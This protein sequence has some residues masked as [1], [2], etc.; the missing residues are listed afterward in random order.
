[1]PGQ[2]VHP[3]TAATTGPLP[4]VCRRVPN[5]CSIGIPQNR[6]HHLSVARDMSADGRRQETGTVEEVFKGDGE[7]E[8][9][10]LE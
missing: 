9:D 3:T 8:G 10:L 7:E 6:Y 5:D 1:M 4:A 2:S